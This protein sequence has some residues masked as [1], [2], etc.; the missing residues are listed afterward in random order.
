MSYSLNSLQG[1]YIVD[2]KGTAI[3]DTKGDARSLDL[4]WLLKEVFMPQIYFR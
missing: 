3:G 2:H 1:G 4:I